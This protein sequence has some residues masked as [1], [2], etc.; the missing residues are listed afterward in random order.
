MFEGFESARV[1]T[2][3][4]EIAV[5]MLVP[6]RPYSS[7]TATPRRTSCGIWSPRSSPTASP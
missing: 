5:G 3:S 7:S 1:K 4:A 6:A 2:S